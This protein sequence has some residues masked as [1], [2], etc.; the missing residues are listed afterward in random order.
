MMVACSGA[1]SEDELDAVRPV[2]GE[3]APVGG[4]GGPEAIPRTWQAPRQLADGVYRLETAGDAAGVVTALWSRVEAPDAGLWASTYRPATGWDE[5]VLLQATDE[6]GLIDVDADRN[7]GALAVWTAWDGAR[8]A[9]FAA[10]RDHATGWGPIE[11][12]DVDDVAGVRDAALDVARDGDAVAVW[13]VGNFPDYDLLARRYDADAGG[14][15]QAPVRVTP[16]PTRALTSQVA[17]DAY[18]AATVAWWSQD[19]EL[20]SARWEPGS[21]WSAPVAIAPAPEPARAMLAVDQRGAVTAVWAG[22][23]VYAARM[24]AFTGWTTPACIS[25]GLPWP[26]RVRLDDAGGRVRAAWSQ[27]DPAGTGAW[28]AGFD[29]FAW[30]PPFAL[31]TAGFEYQAP[32]VGL[33][34]AGGAVALWTQHADATG[35]VRARRVG[36]GGD[37]TDTLDIAQQTGFPQ[38][39]RVEVAGAGSAQALWTLLAPEGNLHRSLWTAGYQ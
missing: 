35:W 28:T 1:G 6:V 15:W 14:G 19:G 26:N 24:E 4:G 5:P 27:W 23:C 9:L 16:G 2:A 31:E 10:R 25:A 30:S 18:D 20:R 17:L 13:T 36:A 7:G 29:G 37:W 38:D 21:A 8:L 34:A 11:R 22:S 39:A 32:D 33:D 3:A 12:L